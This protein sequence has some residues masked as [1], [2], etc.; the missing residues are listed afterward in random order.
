MALYNSASKLADAIMSHPSLIPVLNRLGVSLGVGDGTIGEVCAE[1]H[2]DSDFFLS[3]INTF[4]DEEYFPSHPQNTFTLDK[5]IDYLEKTDNFC[6]RI[7]LPNIDR[8]FT[9]LMEKSGSENNLDFLRRFYFEMRNELTDCLNYDLEILFPSLKK[10][11]LPNGY[12]FLEAFSEIEGKLH[13]LSYFFVQHLRGKYDSNLCT[14]VV[15]AVFAL[16]KEL[17]QNNRIRRRILSPLV[18]YFPG[19]SCQAWKN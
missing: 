18:S 13:D 14:A 10:G 11:L 17:R 9:S 2:I 16:D 19:L 7:Q 1:R 6:L 15:S 3:V 4:L 8:H 5:T 12:D